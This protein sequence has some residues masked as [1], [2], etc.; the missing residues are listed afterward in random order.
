ME[1]RV[2]IA[3]IALW[4]SGCAVIRQPAADGRTP[5]RSLLEIRQAQVVI[6]KWDLSCG[7][8]A[9]ATVLTYRFNDDVPERAIAAA[10]LR[11]TSPERVNARGGFSL[12]D[13]KRF[14][15]GRGY[16]ATGYRQLSY[17]DLLKLD[18]PIVP[19]E[20]KGYSHFVVVR[21]IRGNRV[22]LADPA[23]GNR[24]ITV[25]AFKRAWLGGFGFVLR[26]HD[27]ATST[28]EKMDAS[29]QKRMGSATTSP[30]SGVSLV[31]P[32]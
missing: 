26:H 22:H 30:R 14:A 15:E 1:L 24:I 16:R 8:A 7:A 17:D 23:F 9:L 5:V 29:L 6:Q 20:T 19:I 25:P 32:T 18:T 27:N 10:M 12:L 3:L 4:S 28:G 21:G 2:L 11:H 13:L 31:T